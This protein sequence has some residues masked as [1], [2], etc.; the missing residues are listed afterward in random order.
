MSELSDGDT[1]G[2][3]AGGTNPTDPQLW[4][5]AGA[6]QSYNTFD[7]LSASYLVSL[8]NLVVQSEYRIG[9]V[10]FDRQLAVSDLDTT[11]TALLNATQ[12]RFTGEVSANALTSENEDNTG[13][14]RVLLRSTDH[15]TTTTLTGSMSQDSDTTR[16]QASGASGRFVYRLDTSG[17]DTM[18]LIYN[19]TT[20]KNELQ[21]YDTATTTMYKCLTQSP[22]DIQGVVGSAGLIPNNATTFN[23]LQSFA[24]GLTMTSAP[25][26][27][28]V[29]FSS[30][31]GDLTFASG[32]ELRKDTFLSGGA[33]L[34]DT[35]GGLVDRTSGTLI[36]TTTSL[37]A[38]GTGGGSDIEFQSGISISLPCTML[39]ERKGTNGTTAVYR[40][41]FRGRISFAAS[42]TTVIPL[43]T[44]P[45]Q[46]LPTTEQNFL[47]MG[48]TLDKFIRIDIS[49]AGSVS[50][51]GE[52]STAGSTFANLGQIAFWVGI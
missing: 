4:T 13:D 33:D 52:G 29:A 24:G 25:A 43:F 30:S 11:N 49:T 45:A 21:I 6:T 41:T 19:T 42:S 38:S 16:F 17:A 26:S 31:T 5:G 51:S 44:L 10:G 46:Y 1:V 32:A 34:F 7:N 27:G 40:M 18:Q 20:L 9:N 14:P 3:L 28:N 47:V 50:I 35:V 39:A 15:T 36:P 2:L 22:S 8:G 48:H 12:N 37:V 23:V